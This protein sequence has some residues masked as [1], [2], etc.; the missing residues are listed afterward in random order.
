MPGASSVCN[1]QTSLAVWVTTRGKTK[2]G[3]TE[4]GAKHPHDSVL[5]EFIYRPHISNPLI[6]S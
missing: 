4:V 1:N 6:A 3:P 2:F 5:R